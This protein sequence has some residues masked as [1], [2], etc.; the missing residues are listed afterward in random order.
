MLIQVVDG[1]PVLVNRKDPTKPRLIRKPKKHGLVA[2]KEKKER[3]L[4][5]RK[6]SERELVD[7][8]VKQREAI[9]NFF[10][11]MSK[12]EAGIRAGY[13]ESSAVAG[14]NNALKRAM[15]NER[16]IKAM[17][18]AG[19]TNE[20]LVEILKEG[21]EARHPLKPDQKDYHAIHKFWKDAVEIKQGF[22]PKKI[23]TKSD[24]RHVVIHLDKNMAEAIRG[25]QKIR[26]E[27]IEGE[28]VNDS[29]SSRV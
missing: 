26:G 22:P 4:K 3:R 15:G 1:M 17:E 2:K 10:A 19:L 14:V 28:I 5:M 24:H 11:G 20:R 29:D 23:D 7:L 8:T 25:Y 21:L 27:T 13:S 12:K 18:E 9:K 6:L 16:F